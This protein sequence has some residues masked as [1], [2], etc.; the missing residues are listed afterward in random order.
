MVGKKKNEEDSGLV[1]FTPPPD[2]MI[3]RSRR[4][5]NSQMLYCLQSVSL[6]VYCSRFSFSNTL[7]SLFYR[8]ESLLLFL[9]PF[10]H[11]CHRTSVPATKSPKLA[12]RSQ[13][14]F[15]NGQIRFCRQQSFTV[16]ESW[17]EQD[18]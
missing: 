15:R 13:H 3:R 17:L 14:I 8:M 18:A 16:V 4:Y 9:P 6:T 1:P 7:Y 11:S 5:Q 2:S 10:C 12:R